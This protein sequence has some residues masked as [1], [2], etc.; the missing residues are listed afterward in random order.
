MRRPAP[1]A[2][3]GRATRGFQQ[4]A[5]NDRAQLV[6]L[7]PQRVVL[8][9][10]ST[11]SA[12]RK[13]P[14]SYSPRAGRPQAP[15]ATASAAAPRQRLSSARRPPASAAAN[16]DRVSAIQATTPAEASPASTPIA[17][18]AARA[19]PALRRPQRFVEHDSTARRG[20]ERAGAD[21]ACGSKRFEPL[22]QDE[23]FLAGAP[24]ST[25]DVRR[26]PRRARVAAVERRGAGVQQLVALRAAARRR[27]C[28]R[29]RCTPWPGHGRDRG[30]ARASRR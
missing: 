19:T 3:C 1:A 16:R 15:T 23:R 30:R 6:G 21:A 26:R 7:A 9:A 11:P 12:S 27:R 5:L 10:S 17:I 28:A 4:L 13:R 24:R 2:R 18:Q 25:A 8:T 29:G 20:A 14:S 22:Q